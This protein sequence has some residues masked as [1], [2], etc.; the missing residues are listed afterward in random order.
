MQRASPDSGIAVLLASLL[1]SSPSCH[2]DGALASLKE[3][4]TR[5]VLRCV[6][7]YQVPLAHM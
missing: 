6:R 5:T 7:S 1:L 4:T 2:A 3:G